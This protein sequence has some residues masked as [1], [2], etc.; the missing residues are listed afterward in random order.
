MIV[1]KL[2]VSKVLKTGLECRIAFRLGILSFLNY[3]TNVSSLMICQLDLPSQ[4]D[5]TG[6]KEKGTNP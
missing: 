1:V 4:L 6:W 5:A 2:C 3:S